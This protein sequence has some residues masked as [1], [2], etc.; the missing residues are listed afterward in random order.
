[1]HYEFMTVYLIAVGTV[2]VLAVVLAILL[3]VD[4]VYDGYHHLSLHCLFVNLSKIKEI[5]S[6][7]GVWKTKVKDWPSTDFL[8]IYSRYIHFIVRRNM[9]CCK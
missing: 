5:K 4:V 9:S 3:A 6:S 8:C 2:L 7:K 1:M